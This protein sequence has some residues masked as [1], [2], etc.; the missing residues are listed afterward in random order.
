MSPR[1]FFVRSALKAVAVAALAWSGGSARAADVTPPAA[2]VVIG[3]APVTV[4]A[5]G[6]S[7]CQGHGCETGKP[8]RTRSSCSTCGQLSVG[9]LFKKTPDR[10]PVTLCP[11]ACFGYFQTQWHKWDEVCPYPYLGM[12]ASDSSRTPG[13]SPGKQPGSDT[14]PP[15]PLEPKMIEPKKLGTLELPPIP[16]VNPGSK[17]IP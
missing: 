10:Y 13:A 16:V 11:G 4:G 5:P 8:G 6:C 15:R 2:P 17:V 7:T 3:A 1:S 12:G 14:T 9:S